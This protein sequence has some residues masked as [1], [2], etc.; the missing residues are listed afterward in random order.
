[1]FDPFPFSMRQLLICLSSWPDLPEQPTDDS[2]L[3]REQ[4]K[5]RV[6][7]IE[8]VIEAMQKL[9]QG[10]SIPCHSEGSRD[11][12]LGRWRY[13]DATKP[14]LAGHSLGGGAAV[15][16]LLSYSVVFIRLLNLN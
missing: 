11:F 15:R 13:L 14:V 7:E 12:E 3:R 5:C 2:I 8:A 4:I 1:M 16:E 9:S 10:E 6:A